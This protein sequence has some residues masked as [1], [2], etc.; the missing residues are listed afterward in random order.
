MTEKTGISKE[1]QSGYLHQNFRLFHLKD[2]KTQEF[3]FHYHDFN[4]IIVFLSGN[5]TYLVEGKAYYLKPWDI[6]LVN[7]HD[8]H[9]P[10][11]DPGTTYERIIIWLQNDFIKSQKDRPCDLSACFATAN[12]KSFNLIRLNASLQTKIQTLIHSLEDSLTSEEFG[13]EVLSQTYFLQL[14]V[15]LNQVFSPEQY[16]ED[17]SA[18]R[19]DK[20]IADILKYINLHLDAD[21]SNETLAEKFFLSKYYLMHKFKEETGYTLHNYVQQKRLICA[22]DMIKGGSPILKAASQCGF[23]DYSTFL[24]AFRKMYGMSPKDIIV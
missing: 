8:I 10:I 4:K 5:V 23:S 22:A 24:R 16:Q 3:E 1:K 11:I 20:Q 13:H 7:H 21:L 9:K 17:Q 15:Y 2:K 18:S 6:L 14:M 19:Y 12:E